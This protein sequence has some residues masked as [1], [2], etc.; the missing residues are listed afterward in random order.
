MTGFAYQRC[1]I[2][3]A[4]EA[5]ARC[6]ECRRAFCRECVVDH[7]GRLVC[8]ACIASLHA[9]KARGRGLLRRVFPAAAALLTLIVCWILFYMAGR[10]LLLNE[11]SRH[12]FDETPQERHE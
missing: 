4:R 7:E 3:A 1:F 5:V 9:P 8:A 12:S 10:V 11:P 2:H 6:L